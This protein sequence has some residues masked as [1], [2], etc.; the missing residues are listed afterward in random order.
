MAKQ[1]RFSAFAHPFSTRPSTSGW[2]PSV[3]LLRSSNP[4]LGF[5]RFLSFVWLLSSNVTT[6]TKTVFPKRF[7]TGELQTP[8]FELLC[9]N[10]SLTPEAAHCLR[11]QPIP[12]LSFED[13]QQIVRGI[14]LSFVIFN[15]GLRDSRSGVRAWI[16]VKIAYESKVGFWT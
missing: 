16:Q 1:A 10:Q 4:P 12:R 3:Q 13:L 6:Q 8:A 11:P 15:Y 2:S 14:N 9:S 7:E 5:K